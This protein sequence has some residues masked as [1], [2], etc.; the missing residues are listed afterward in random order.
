[1]KITEQAA[2]K[3]RTLL[4]NK[5][6]N[7]CPAYVQDVIA[8]NK[9]SKGRVGMEVDITVAA[10]ALTTQMQDMVRQDGFN[11]TKLIRK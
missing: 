1:M 10:A 11:Y 3:K 9:Y 8:Q 7:Q 4:R 6:E 5:T 2:P